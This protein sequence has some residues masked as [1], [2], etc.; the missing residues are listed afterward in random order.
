[1]FEKMKHKLFGIFLLILIAVL[2]AC[3]TPKDESYSL[4]FELG[5]MQA[6]DDMLSHRQTFMKDWEK[7]KEKSILKYCKEF[8][9]KYPT[10]Y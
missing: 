6:V 2:I 8:N 3:N 5:Y 10:K 1:M 7:Y 4:T 9:V